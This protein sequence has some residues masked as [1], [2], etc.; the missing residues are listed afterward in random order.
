[1]ASKYEPVREDGT[2][3]YV[4]TMSDWGKRREYEVYA[5]DAPSARHR[6]LGRPRTGVYI[7][8]VKRKLAAPT[9][10]ETEEQ[11]ND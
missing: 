4:V 9:T 6:A 11:N 5:K 7:L 1:M 3:G 2:K 8:G 10:T